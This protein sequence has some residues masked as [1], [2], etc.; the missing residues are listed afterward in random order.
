M[1]VLI[2]IMLFS[3]SLLLS[4]NRFAFSL[5]SNN[6]A[7]KSNDSVLSDETF[8]YWFSSRTATSSRSL[9]LS[10]QYYGDSSFGEE[11]ASLNDEVNVSFMEGNIEIV[12]Q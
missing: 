5:I 11:I 1:V 3:E 6:A 2:V 9:V 10:Y 4:K 8:S 7:N 12:T